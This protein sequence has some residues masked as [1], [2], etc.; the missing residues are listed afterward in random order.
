MMKQL[1]VLGVN[2]LKVMLTKGMKVSTM[3]I[4]I[5]LILYL[6]PLSLL[7][8]NSSLLQRNLNRLFQKSLLLISTHRSPAV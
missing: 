2:L 7:Y 3:T 5:Q 6:Q 8:T 1:P 4:Q